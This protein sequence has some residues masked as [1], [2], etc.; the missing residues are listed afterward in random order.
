M[1]I[2]SRHVRTRI[3]AGNNND[4]IRHLNQRGIATERLIMTTTTIETM[5][6]NGIDYVR[7]DSVQSNPHMP[8][9]NKRIIVADKGWVFAGDCEDH[10]DG[11]VTIH[12]AKNI[13]NWGT[14]KGLGEL[15][16]GPLGSIK[17]DPYG[18]V[19]C[20]PLVQIN[21]IKGW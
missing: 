19:R 10:T 16:N 9:T 2:I 12:N 15:V 14:S 8:M 20:M 6:I 3:C 1:G 11:S 18:T 5:K 13:R 7:A 4:T 21:V 17:H